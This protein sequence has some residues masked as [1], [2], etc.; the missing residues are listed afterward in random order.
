MNS[1]V[2]PVLSQQSIS[3]LYSSSKWIIST[4]S[5]IAAKWSGVN[6]FLSVILTFA[7]CFNKSL[8]MVLFPLLADTWSAVL[9]SD[10]NKTSLEND[11]PLHA[12]CQTGCK[13]IVQL[14]LDKKVDYNQRNKSGNTPLHVACTRFK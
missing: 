6:P 10:I 11:S 2:L 13:E 14:L 3:A 12:A 5:F 4:W 7:S 8:V 1:G 9:R